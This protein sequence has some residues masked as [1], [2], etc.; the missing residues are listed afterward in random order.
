MRVVFGSS[1]VKGL[2]IE[3][4]PH[5]LVIDSV[6]Q[7]NLIG[8]LHH[9]GSMGLDIQGK[10]FHDMGIMKVNFKIGETVEMNWSTAKTDFY[11]YIYIYIYIYI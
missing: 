3:V 11:G 10:G 1:L 6:Y 7:G 8:S 5:A 4:C 9:E 2:D